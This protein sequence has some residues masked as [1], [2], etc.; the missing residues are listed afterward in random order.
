M[1]EA[2]GGPAGAAGPGVAAEELE[3]RFEAIARRIAREV[4]TEESARQR[5][6][7]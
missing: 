6:S 7:R 1:A 5:R 3:A 4:M 2:P